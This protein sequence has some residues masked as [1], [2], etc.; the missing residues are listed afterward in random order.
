MIR[1]IKYTFKSF[2]DY[3]KVTGHNDKEF[4]P[5]QYTRIKTEDKVLYITFDTCPTDECDF[6]IVDWLIEEKIPATIFLNKTWYTQNEDK[7]L[8]FLKLP[9]FS[10]GGHGYH[11]ERPLRQSYREQNEDITQCVNFI[12]S[13]LGKK[14]K[15]YRS[16]YGKPNEDTTNILQ[17]FGIRY[18]S[19]AGPVFDKTAPDLPNP[20]ELARIYLNNGVRP[21]DIWVFHINGEGIETLKI[22]KEAYQWG[23]DN[24]YRFEKL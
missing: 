2:Y 15:W 13:E 23:I 17:D 16:P 11:H 14:I 21:G 3:V 19:W 6:D 20:N 8:G 18:A 5:K 24:G 1:P 22:L 7:G 9:Q 4:D 12:Y 10:I